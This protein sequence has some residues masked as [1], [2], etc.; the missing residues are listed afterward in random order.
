MR[1]RSKDNSPPVQQLQKK[2]VSEEAAIPTLHARKMSLR[3]KMSANKVAVEEEVIGTVTLVKK[4]KKLKNAVTYCT[5]CKEDFKTIAAFDRHVTDTHP[6]TTFDCD[7]C[8]ASYTSQAA[9]RKHVTTQHVRLA[10]TCTTCGKAFAYKSLLLTHK[11]VHSEDRP[12]VCEHDGCTCTYTTKAALKIHMIIHENKK[13]QCDKCTFVTDTSQNLKQHMMTHG[14][15]K[16]CPKC[17]FKYLWPTQL[18]RH[19]KQSGH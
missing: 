13:F 15:K 17:T 6:G 2:T 3:K 1:T 11:R 4:S 9:Y 8:D 10:Y 12:F 18:Y 5:G 7:N 14:K 16:T 19:K